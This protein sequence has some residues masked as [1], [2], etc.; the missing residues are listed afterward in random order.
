MNTN[1][2]TK[3]IIWK[4]LERGSAQ[5]ISLIVQ[6]IL[7]RIVAPKDFGILAI[8]MVF[9]NISNVFIQK[10]F[11]SSLI[12]KEKVTDD[13]YNTAF[14]VSEIFAIVI[15]V[16]LCIFSNDI[17]TYYKIPSLGISLKIISL[18]LVFGAFYSIQNAELIRGM[19][20][21]QIFIRSVIASSLSGLIGIILAVLGYGVW[22]LII[23]TL[24]QQ[25]VICIVTMFSC[26]WKPKIHFSKIS[27]IELFSF[28]SKILI[29]ELISIGIENIRTLFIGKKFTSSDLAF[30]DRGQLYPA[31]GMRSVYD[32]I[33]SVLLPVFSRDQKNINNLAKNIEK[34]I[35]MTHFFVFPIFIG[36]AAVAKPFVYLLLTEKWAGCIPYLKLFCVYQLAFPIY[37]IIRQ[38]LY[39]LGKSGN[40]LKLEIVR[41]VLFL[42]ALFVGIIFSP[43]VVALLSLAAMYITT[44]LYFI[45]TYKLIKYNY[46]SI[47]VST[48]KIFI[49]CVVMFFVINCINKLAISYVLMLILDVL[50]GI[51][52][53]VTL[54]IITKNEAFNYCW[55]IIKNKMN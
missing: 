26:S 36:F 15:I 7:A 33:N 53:Y 3:S 41:S 2:I 8:L 28:G 20:F 45:H 4:F 34:T 46:V 43:F 51:I 40:V 37:G 19:K 52:I 49:Q 14:I 55:K 23:Q 38:S 27:F 25:V 35:C 39:A 31:T 32:A 5:I 44:L 6:I 16:V 10:G 1:R 21:R 11:S 13:D 30:Y 47:V 48:F 18:S 50:V 24:L 42:I 9:I 29:A 54:S 12:R 17:E 22:A